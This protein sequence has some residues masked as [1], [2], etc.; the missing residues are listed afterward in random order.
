MGWGMGETMIAAATLLWSIEVVVAKRLLTGISAPLLAAS[1]MG[2]GLVVLVGY[3]AFTGRL[4]GLGA[5]GAEA[6]F[7]VLITGVMLAG[8]VATWYGA[9]R[10]APAT[11][12]TSILVAAAV[13]T[14]VLSAASTG[15]TPSPTVVTGYLL[16]LAGVA[17]VAFL[18][19]RYQG[20]P[21]SLAA[22]PRPDVARRRAS[23]PILFARYAYGPNRLGL[24]GP[25]DT[26]ALFGEGSTD[27]DERELRELA[28]GFEGALPY[29]QLIAR[30]NA[31][32]DPLD[33]R[34]VEAIANQTF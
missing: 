10:L 20:R 13:V 28:R 18:S 29:L 26:D 1:S 16:V 32:P 31:I 2:L 12:V 11:T 14:G 23:G 7:W 21:V 30:A 24:C 4:G 27:G 15:S 25:D 3:L 9:L 8:Y 19:F 6:W 34:V 22:Q 33:R 5:I 17:V